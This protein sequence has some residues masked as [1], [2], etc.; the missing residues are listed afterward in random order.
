MRL[1][2]PL[3]DRKHELFAII[4]HKINPIYKF[5]R[6]NFWRKVCYKGSSQNIFI[7]LEFNKTRFINDPLMDKVKNICDKPIRIVVT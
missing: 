2:L 7:F 1:A 6:L 3:N 5:L 4:I